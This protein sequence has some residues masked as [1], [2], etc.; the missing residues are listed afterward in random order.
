MIIP[1]LNCLESKR[2]TLTTQFK[3]GSIV[4]Q[5]LTNPTATWFGIVLHDRRLTL[6]GPAYHHYTIAWFAEQ[7]PGDEQPVPMRL[8]K[9]LCIVEWCNVNLTLL[10]L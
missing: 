6:K 7:G 2:H 9:Q 10:L 8:Y 1:I 5:G 3:K 4:A